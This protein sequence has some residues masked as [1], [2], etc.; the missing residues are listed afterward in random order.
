MFLTVFIIG[1]FLI[2]GFISIQLMSNF[3]E[4]KSKTELQQTAHHIATEID[5]YFAENMVI[6]DQM[7]TNQD[8]F[9]VIEEIKSQSE[10]RQHPLF[11][12]VTQELQAIQA[13]EENISLAY[14]AI[15]Q[16]NDLITSDASFDSAVDYQMNQR[17]WYK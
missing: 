4:E 11:N 7:K 15:V 10:K 12:T 3:F 13:S 2:Y 17:D 8:Y 5:K 9:T 1:V 14:I 6:V 16:A